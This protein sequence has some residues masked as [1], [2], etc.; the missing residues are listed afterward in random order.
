MRSELDAILSTQRFFA[1]V[2]PE[3]W[4]I[5]TD[6]EAG[7]PPERPF[8]LI[9]QAGG[10]ETSGA[11]A[12]QD[13]LLPVTA[14]LFLPGQKTREAATDVALAVR[15]TVWQAVKWG[16]D[17]RRPTTDRI[18]LYCYEPRLE[19][20]RFHV[21]WW[22]TDPVT[23]TVAGATT[24]PVSR[25]STAAE[26]AEAIAAALAG[27][28]VRFEPGAIVG[29]DRGTG[30]WD[31]WYGGSLAGE[32]IGDPAI[33]HGRARTLLQGA[34]SP[35]RAPSDYMRVDSFAQNTVR[36][37]ADPTLVMVAVDLRL[38]FGRGLPLPLDQRIIQRVYATVGSGPGG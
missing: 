10:A 31:V 24:D 9:E 3:P 30:L 23:I 28:G 12:T 13:I 17:A 1:G 2:L 34:P 29:Y 35:W 14:N 4:D 25:A 22:V 21:P 5:R 33:S 18:P 7:E 6:L 16:P 15:D 8:V 26:V 37:P 36:D 20:H 11:P 19:E 27:H 38:T 32:R